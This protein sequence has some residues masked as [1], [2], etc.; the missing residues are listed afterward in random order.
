MRRVTLVI[1]KLGLVVGDTI[2]IKLINSVGGLLLSNSGY[3][4][5]KEVTLSSELFYFYF[6]E[7]E[8]IDS[9]SSYQITLPSSLIFTFKVPVS[10][11]NIPHDILSLLRLGCTKGIIDTT[12]KTLDID[13]VK[14]L[15]IYFTGG[16]P[17]F[18]STQ[19]DVVALYDYYADE[20]IDTNSTIDV[21]Q[22][23]DEYL[24]TIKATIKETIEEEL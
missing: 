23:M 5:D 21:M 15:D 16:N 11:T 19:R 17:Y 1:K 9:L 14:K 3:M 8:H 4:L 24:A 20:V 13:F 12:S 18:T 2:D 6:L 22:M 10:N 7:N